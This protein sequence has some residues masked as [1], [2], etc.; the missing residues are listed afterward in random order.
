[1][2]SARFSVY[3]RVEPFDDKD[4]EKL[5]F[6]FQFQALGLVV[7]QSRMAKALN[8]GATEPD[9]VLEIARPHDSP[10]LHSW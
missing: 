3:A 10:S 5:R 9:T 8:M 1:M 2:L 7:K 4:D 6:R